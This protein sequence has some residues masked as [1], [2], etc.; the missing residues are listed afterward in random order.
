MILQRSSASSAPQYSQE[1]AV[2]LTK[3]GRAY[4]VGVIRRGRAR[5]YYSTK[6]SWKLHENDEYWNGE[7]DRSKICL[8]RSA[9]NV[10]YLRRLFINFEISHAQMYANAN[11]E[12][13]G[14]E[15][16]ETSNL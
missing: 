15:N 14:S 3:G 9:N 7:G 2:A 12:R 11:T 16:Q 8:C 13:Y 10:H 1:A 4:L 6:L 5:T